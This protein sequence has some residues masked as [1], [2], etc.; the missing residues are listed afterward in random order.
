MTEDFRGN[1][2]GLG[3]KTLSIFLTVLI[4]LSSSIE[5]LKGSTDDPVIYVNPLGSSANVG[6]YFNVTLEIKYAVD[7]YAWQVN[8]T[9]DPSIVQCVNATLPPDHF[10]AGAPEGVIGLQ[11]HIT[12]HS[13]VVATAILGFYEGMHGSGVLVTIEFEV[14]GTGE[15]ALAIDDTPG[16]E[17]WT[18]LTDSDFGYTEP[19]ELKTQDGFFTTSVDLPIPSFTWSPSIPSIE[20]FVDFNASASYDLDG[21]IVE[22]SWDFG[23]GHSGTGIV[24]SHQY[25]MVGKYVVSLT[26]TDNSSLSNTLYGTLEVGQYATGPVHN[27]DTGFYYP[28]IQEAI[29]DTNTLD[30]HTIRVDAG[31][32]HERVL[33]SK[34]LNLIGEDPLTTIIDGSGE[35][36]VLRIQQNWPHPLTN[37][38]ISGF[39]VRNGFAGIWISSMW[40]T[41]PD[42]HGRANITNNVAKDNMVGISVE[43]G[44][45]NILRNNIMTNNIYNLDLHTSEMNDVDT[46]NTVNGNPVYYLTNQRDLLIDPV[47][48]PSVGY[49]ALINCTDITI[50]DLTLSGNGQGVLLKESR[51]IALLSN[52]ITNNIYGVDAAAVDQ[53]QF[54]GNTIHN[55]GLGMMLKVGN[56]NN[57][58]QNKFENNTSLN[59]PSDIPSMHGGVH[60]R[61]RESFGGD[62]GGLSLFGVTSSTIIGNTIANNDEGI[63]LVYCSGN[64]LR[65]NTM[66]ANILNFGVHAYSPQSS[67]FANDIDT[68]NT[69]NG[70]PIVWWIDQHDKQVPLDA[71]YVA[72]INSTNISIKNLNMSQNRQG[73]LIVSSNN[74]VTSGNKISGVAYGIAIYQSYKQIPGP[75]YTPNNNA[76]FNNTVTDSGTGVLLR[77]GWNHTV[78]FNTLSNNLA[79]I[80]VRGASATMIVGNIVTMSTYPGMH[81]LPHESWSWEISAY[82]S[83]GIIIETSLN[84]I[85]GNTVTYNDIGMVVGLMTMKGNNTI[86]HN[87]FIGNTNQVH[88]EPRNPNTWDDDYPSSGNHWSDY[89]GVDLYSGL[90]QNETGSDGIGDTAYHI[91]TNNTDNYPLI[92]PVNFFDAGTWNASSYSVE[93]VSNSTVSDFY[94][95]PNE[96]AFLRFDVTGESGTRGFCRV[97]IPQ[98]LLHAENGQWTVLVD[99]EPVEYA[100]TADEDHTYIYFI[101]QQS[102]KTVEI[103]GT[104]VIDT[105]PT[106]SILSPENKTYT[107]KDVPLT[108]TVS[109]STSWIGHSL[110]GQA[111]VTIT[112][113]KTLS[114]L[115]EGLHS[116]IV[117]ANDTVG[118]MGASETAYFTIETQQAVAFPIEIVA[119]IVIIGVVGV[120]VLV[121][122]IKFR[123]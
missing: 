63:D 30:G 1:Q 85:R 10:L 19:P 32:Y 98:D 65:N 87:N 119:A 74:T 110:D 83:T 52:E 97:A 71:G 75:I 54:V 73:I 66:T 69:V 14:V 15:S 115:S 4:V 79:G 89:T 12:S 39:T 5:S 108:F 77:S 9:F 88:V 78:S 6:E 106:I 7:V 68:S 28:T 84:I 101:Y 26:V 22:Y 36:T 25:S 90:Y 35:G 96:G 50:R 34:S 18:Y 114:D 3:K 102:T 112:G 31:I 48:F 38:T 44:S 120:V 100:T 21:S 121:Y 41:S 72:I 103:Q 37:V 51:N 62:S 91:Y 8:L 95:N 58:T 49:L 43:G 99:G 109:E 47:A 2:M 20:G 107:A 81:A 93:V 40:T 117:Y 27:I 45:Q 53:S 111:N 118:N 80:V 23:D 24:T 86:Y 76:V 104:Y 59:V 105:I 122:F 42:V 11:K 92:N 56:F 123:K 94:F 82:G 64:T 33:L 60:Y 61:L 57:I 67:Y 116:L 29:D 13:M 16:I 113:N 70:K 17:A 46:T 55:N